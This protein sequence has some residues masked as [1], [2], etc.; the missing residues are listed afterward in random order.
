MHGQRN[1]KNVI[2]IVLW[3]ENKYSMR[4]AHVRIGRDGTTAVHRVGYGLEEHIYACFVYYCIHTG[5]VTI[6]AI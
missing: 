5:S 1:I 3:W 2:N 4:I 6:T